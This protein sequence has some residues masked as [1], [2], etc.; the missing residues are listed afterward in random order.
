VEIFVEQIEGL[1]DGGADVAWIET[2]AEPMEI[3]A[4]ARAAI[5]VGLPYVMT[6][7]FERGGKTRTGMS[8]DFF[9]KLIGS[10]EVEPLA[11]GASCGVGAADLLISI[12]DMT[13]SRPGAAVVAKASAGLPQWHGAQ[14]HYPG[15]PDLMAIYAGLAIDAGARIV[16]GCC[17]TTPAHLA[18]MRRALDSHRPGPRPDVTRIVAALGPL[19]ARPAAAFA[20]AAERAREG[21]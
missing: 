20:F 15:T 14:I 12:L 8:P 10:F 21:A 9:A 19:V 17:G 13:E 11:F 4:A 16:G 18:A 2:M 3:Q 7:S 5:R 6:A 1:R